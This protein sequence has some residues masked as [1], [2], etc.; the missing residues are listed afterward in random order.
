MAY[1]GDFNVIK[2]EEDK[3][4]GFLVYPQEYEVFIFCLNSC[5]LVDV[6]F[7]SSLFTWWNRKVNEDCIFKRLDRVVINWNLQDV[8]GNIEIQNLARTRSDHVPL[9]IT[10][11][12]DCR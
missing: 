12:V 3:I 9:L 8:F 7:T 10:C 6:P 5:E 1:G 4:G 11:S 2:S